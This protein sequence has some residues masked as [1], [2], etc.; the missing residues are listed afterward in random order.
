[1]SRPVT[2][3]PGTQPVVPGALQPQRA[4]RRRSAQ[5]APWA[6][7][8]LILPAAVLCVA[9]IVAPVVYITVNSFRDWDPGYASPWVGLDNYVELLSS[10]VFREVLGNEFFYLLGLPVWVAVPLF[11]SFLLHDRVPSAGWF[12]TVFFLPA[13]LSPAV[14]GVVFRYL[15]VPDG[16]VN[17]GLRAIGLDALTR[18][19]LADSSTVKPTVIIII[20]WAGFGTGVLIFSAGLA[21]LPPEQI[22]AARIDGANVVQQL[23]HVVVPGMVPLIALYTVLQVVNVFLWS[24]PWIYVL[25]AG[26]PGNSSSTLDF[27]IYV[28]TLS[29]GR[30]GLGAA[31]AVVLMLLIGA[32]VGVGSLVTTVSRRGR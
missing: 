23:W 22:E 6:D 21:A 11:I 29:F 28:T 1:M 10:P 8:W 13:I 32:L 24:F 5:P 27:D 30:Y 15:L 9:I 25:T 19:W 16:P 20:L 7:V 12:R 4:R 18:N 17:E 26:G 14:V 3:S 2:P 31:E